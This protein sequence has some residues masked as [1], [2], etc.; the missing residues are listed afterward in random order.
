MLNTN[1]P[2][3]SLEKLFRN[4]PQFRYTAKQI[5]QRLKSEYRFS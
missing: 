5:R 2:N 3:D 1:V 4:R